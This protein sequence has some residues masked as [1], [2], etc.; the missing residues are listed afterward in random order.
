MR[1]GIVDRMEG[2]LVVVEWDNGTMGEVPLGA[3]ADR[4]TQGDVFGWEEG[5]AQL[6]PGETVKRKEQVQRI[7]DRLKKSNC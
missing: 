1:K 2:A 4:P 7:F 3:F 6:L 5:R